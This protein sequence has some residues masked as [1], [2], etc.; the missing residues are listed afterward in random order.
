M[1][2]VRKKGIFVSESYIKYIWK[3]MEHLCKILKYFIFWQE[4]TSFCLKIEDSQWYYMLLLSFFFTK[5]SSAFCVQLFAQWDK[6]SAIAASKYSRVS[7][8]PEELLQNGTMGDF[9]TEH[10]FAT[11]DE[12]QWLSEMKE[13]MLSNGKC[14]CFWYI[15]TS[16]S[17]MLAVVMLRWDWPWTCLCDIWF[18]PLS[19][20]G[21]SVHVLLAYYFIKHIH[22]IVLTIKTNQ[23]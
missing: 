10:T 3:E 4:I 18:I 9:G 7:G 16:E 14:E 5:I 21:G 22:F 19:K 23:N 12:G 20:A 17:E 11:I 8:N 6:K 13:R 1:T 15:S 2:N